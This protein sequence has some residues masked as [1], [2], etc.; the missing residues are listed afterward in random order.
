MVIGSILALL[1]SANEGGK[2][3]TEVGLLT[4]GT[5]EAIFQAY[6]PRNDHA[7]HGDFGHPRLLFKYHIV[8]GKEA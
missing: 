2:Y 3:N 4:P 1:F 5:E 6:E 7:V 8:V